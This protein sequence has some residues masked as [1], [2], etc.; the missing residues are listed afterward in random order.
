MPYT[1]VRAGSCIAP[2]SIYCRRERPLRRQAHS[3]FS[4]LPLHYSDIPRTSS[5]H[6]ITYTRIFI[7]VIATLPYNNLIFQKNRI[8]LLAVAPLAQ[9][10]EQRPFKSWVQGS[11][12]WG[13]TVFIVLLLMIALR[14]VPLP[15]PLHRL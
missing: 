3:R 12:P 5:S 9:W 13:G 15:L 4:A 14:S 2:G 11:S 10:L 1:G 6:F 8:Y 7:C